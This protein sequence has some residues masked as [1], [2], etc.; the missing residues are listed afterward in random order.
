M[1]I[2][3]RAFF[4]CLQAWK[5]YLATLF[6]KKGLLVTLTILRRSNSAAVTRSC[7]CAGY[8]VYRPKRTVKT[9]SIFIPKRGRQ[10]VY[11]LYETLI[12]Y[13]YKLNSPLK[14]HFT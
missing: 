10:N 8:S 1:K 5:D 3:F 13:P 11:S 6:L 9:T 12:I 2:R 4:L 14:S 7:L